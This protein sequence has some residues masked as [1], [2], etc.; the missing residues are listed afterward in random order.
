MI[1]AI[2]IASLATG[3]I[4]QANVGLATCLCLQDALWKTYAPQ[5]NIKCTWAWVNT[6]GNCVVPKGLA[7]NF[8]DYP[9]DFGEACKI[10]EDPGHSACYDLTT[11]P[12]Q[13]KPI[14]EQADWCLEEW[15]YIDPCS[16]DAADATKSDYFPGA[17]FYSYATCGAK[18]TYTAAESAT[19]T[20]GNAECATNTETSD[21]QSLTMGFGML[22]AVMGTMA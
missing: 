22:L 19:N 14:S 2:I 11:I 16:C 18:N 4:A 20:V 1:R 5:F 13:V 15:C 10:W 7:S 9:G 6:E 12:P 21:A 8:T 3:A 17:L